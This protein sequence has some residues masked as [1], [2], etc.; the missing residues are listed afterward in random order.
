M[1]SAF[2]MC[3]VLLMVTAAFAADPG[4]GVENS[5]TAVGVEA[6]GG[7]DGYGYQYI[8]STENTGL[9]P[10]YSWVDITGTGTGLGLDDDGETNIP[11]GFSF[12]FYGVDY[13]NAQVGNNGGV[14]LSATGDVWAGNLCPMPYTGHE[15]PAFWV[16]WDDM[17]T[18]SGDVYYE[19]QGSCS[20]PDCAGACLIV[21][22]YDRP[23]YPG[24]GA[25]TATFEAIF[26]DTGDIIAQYQ[27]LDFGDPTLDYGASATV[28]IEDDTA[29]VTYFLQYSCDTADLADGLAVK[30]TTGPVPV[31]LQRIDIE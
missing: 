23:H 29:D 22:W 20:H 3:S 4:K 14:L 15:H 12:P 19:T 9:E 10:T 31:D 2:V 13:S 17:D 25:S 7:P 6:I 1:K 24:P 30:Y 21:E 27:D 11:I 5:G 26:C 8:D 16:F 18:E 28:G